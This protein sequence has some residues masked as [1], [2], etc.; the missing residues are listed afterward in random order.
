MMPRS[1]S[2][3]TMYSLTAGIKISFPDPPDDIN[4][5]SACRKNL[6]NPPQVVAACCADGHVNDVKVE[7]RIVVESGEFRGGYC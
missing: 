2:T 3:S 5:V 1:T 7:K 4:V 6:L